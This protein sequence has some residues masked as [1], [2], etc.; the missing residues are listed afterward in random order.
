MGGASCMLI[1]IF[2]CPVW[3]GEDLHKAAASNL[4]KLATYLEGSH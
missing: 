3:A 4:E 1:S 2:I